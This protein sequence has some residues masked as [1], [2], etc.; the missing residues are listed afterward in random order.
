MAKKKSQ[1]NEPKKLTMAEVSRLAKQA[2]R[3]KEVVL[4][5]GQYKMKIHE[6]FLESDIQRFV[7]DLQDA[8]LVLK[9]ENVSATDITNY[10]IIYQML[11]LKHFADVGLRH[12]KIDKK[13]VKKLLGIAKDLTDIGIFQMIKDIFD[14]EELN[15]IDEYVQKFELVNKELGDMLVQAVL[16]EKKKLNDLGLD[17]TTEDVEDG[18]NV[19]ES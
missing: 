7:L 11:L 5:D 2:Q 8:L 16:N 6:N 4:L 12:I 19:Q 10:L 3:Y 1:E 14:I 18:E 9:S 15:K 13:G 17:I